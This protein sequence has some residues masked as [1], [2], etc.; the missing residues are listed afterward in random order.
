MPPIKTLFLHHGGTPVRGSEVYL[1]NLLARLDRSVVEPIV[2]CDDPTF[3]E[4]VVKR[5]GLEP[6][7]VPIP[8][9]MIDGGEYRFQVGQWFQ[10]IACLRR[11]IR[12]HGVQLAYCNNGRPL[13]SAYF[14]SRWAGIPA[15][16][17]V[18]TPYNRR[19]ILLYRL[20]KA[21][22]VIFCSKG[23]ERKIL[24]KEHFQA[25]YQTIP[26]GIDT[27]LF[28]PPKYRE[29]KLRADFGIPETAVVIGQVGSMIDRKGID[30][31]LNAFRIVRQQHS[32]AWLALVGSGPRLEHFK[33]MARELLLEDRVMFLGEQAQTDSFYKHLIDIN[34]LGSRE[35]AC[36]FSLLEGAAC[37]LPSV[38]SDV[39]GIPEEIDD[40]RSGFL[41]PV[42]DHAALAEHLCRLVASPD[43]RLQFGVAARKLIENRY[44]MSANVR[45][46]EQV[47]EGQVQNANRQ[48]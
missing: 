10:T 31:L 41:F 32:Q 40:G 9:I 13:Q 28:T 22:K 15:V 18:H 19:Y 38:G 2:A 45:Q 42:E 43:L 1:L 4:A 11:L 17:H 6:L 12:R 27:N 8:Q 36:P 34:V 25:A 39:D 29:G 21:S 24:S 7:H 37:G 5:C 14:A 23:I 16:C 20:H 47:I 30:I 46:V 3:R 48:P 35:D 26:Y 44:S 33:S